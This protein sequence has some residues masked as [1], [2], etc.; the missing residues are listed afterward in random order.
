MGIIN[1]KTLVLCDQC[2]NKVSKCILQTH[3]RV[4][5]DDVYLNIVPVNVNLTTYVLKEMQEH[6]KSLITYCKYI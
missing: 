3:F 6:K 2:T 1:L 4:F 5:Y